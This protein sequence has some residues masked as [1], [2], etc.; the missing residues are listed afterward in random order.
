VNPFEVIAFIGSVISDPRMDKKQLKAMEQ[1]A[2]DFYA[3]NFAGKREKEEL[4]AFVATMILILGENLADLRE[5]EPDVEYG[6]P[7]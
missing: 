3:E 2:N 1:Y 7:N 6:S 4:C 5:G